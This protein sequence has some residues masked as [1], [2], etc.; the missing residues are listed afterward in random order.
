MV[1]AK[2]FLES[3]DAAEIRRRI[4]Q[5]DNEKQALVVLHRAAIRLE[6]RRLPL[7]NDKQAKGQRGSR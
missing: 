7:S 1:N 3:L 6:R 4:E 2:Q 5:L